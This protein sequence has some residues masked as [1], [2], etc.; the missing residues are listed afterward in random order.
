MTENPEKTET[1]IYNNIPFF[2][3]IKRFINFNCMSTCMDLFDA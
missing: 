2:R 3:V 1:F